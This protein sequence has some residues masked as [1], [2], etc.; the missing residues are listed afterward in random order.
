MLGLL[1]S[2]V[3]GSVAAAISSVPLVIAFVI[4]HLIVMTIAS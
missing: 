3:S 2:L 4:A 1:K